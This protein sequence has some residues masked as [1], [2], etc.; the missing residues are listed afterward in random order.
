V[1][2]QVGLSVVRSRADLVWQG[3]QRQPVP[4][5]EDRRPLAQPA[6]PATGD[7]AGP[8][9]SGLSAPCRTTA[10]GCR[11]GT[12]R[13][14]VR[15]PL[16]DARRRRWPGPRRYVQE[17]S[18]VAGDTRRERARDLFADAA[19]CSGHRGDTAAQF[20]RGG[21]GVPFSDCGGRAAPDPAAERGGQLD[22]GSTRGANR[23]A[24]R[25]RGRRLPDRFHRR[26]GRH[27]LRARAPPSAQGSMPCRAAPA[28]AG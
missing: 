3:Q 1:P 27:C 11:P 13:Q 15:C 14:E 10:V 16:P 2:G 24:A 22:R 8:V 7:G 23:H 17:R 20:C 19:G 21:H 26:P 5:G 4:A 18:P 25:G 28:R 12:R 9:G 6:G